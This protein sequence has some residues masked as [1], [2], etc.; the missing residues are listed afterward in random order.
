MPSIAVTSVAATSITVNFTTITAGN[1]NMIIRV[2]NNPNPVINYSNN[3][4]PFTIPTTATLTF[5]Y[6]NFSNTNGSRGYFHSN[7]EPNN[8]LI[9]NIYACNAANSTQ[10]NNGFDTYVTAVGFINPLFLSQTFNATLAPYKPLGID[11]FTFFIRQTTP[12]ITYSNIIWPGYSTA[13]VVSTIYTLP[14]S[15]F[16]SGTTPFIPVGGSNYTF[17]LCNANPNTFFNSTISTVGGAVS[18]FI[19]NPTTTSVD[20]VFTTMDILGTQSTFSLTVN[21]SGNTYRN[22]SWY[23]YCN[24][25]TVGTY[26]TVLFKDFTGTNGSLLTNIR[27]AISY[28]VNTSNDFPAYPL[29]TTQTFSSMPQKLF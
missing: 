27:N 22:T 12:A 3:I 21:D 14:Y 10:Y 2:A 5:Y 8:A 28:T 4:G 25:P 18:T 16:K 19:T 6:S 15:D 11:T 13:P 20:I 26:N 1:Y 24:G 17:S 7:I 9:Y 23:G 29:S